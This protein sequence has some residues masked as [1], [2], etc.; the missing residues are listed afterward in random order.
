M[1]NEIEQKPFSDCTSESA[2]RLSSHS[3]SYN[4]LLPTPVR[5]ASLSAAELLLHHDQ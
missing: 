3:E 1:R 5:N 2:R 4:A